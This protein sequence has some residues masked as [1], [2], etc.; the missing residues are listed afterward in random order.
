[1]GT[2]YGGLLHRN[3]KTNISQYYTPPENEYYKAESKNIYAITQNHGLLWMA[4]AAGLYSFDMRSK[5][6]VQHINAADEQTRQLCAL[7]KCKKQNKILCGGYKGELRFFNLQ[8]NSW[9]MPPDKN[10]FMKANTFRARYMEERDNGDVYISTEQRCLIKYNY[11]SGVFTVYPQFEKYSATSRYFC[12]DSSYLWIAT[13]DGLIQ[14]S[15]KQMQVIKVWT[16]VNGLLNDYVYGAVPYKPG[17]IW[18]S[19]NS[20]LSL[21]DYNKNNCINYT[22]NDGLQ[23]NEFNTASC[24]KDEPGRIWFGGI[25]GMNMIDTGGIATSS[26]IP[27]PLLT[28]IRVMN[29]PLSSDSAVSYLHNIHLSYKNNFL[30]FEF[31]C[32]DYV[33]SDNINYRYKMTGIDTGWINNESRNAVNF[34]QLKPG[35]YRFLVQ[36]FLGNNVW[37]NTSQPIEITI[38]TPWYNQWWFYVLCACTISFIT[39]SI[40]KYRIAQVRK[41]YQ[42]QQRISSD[43]HDDIGASLT[44]INIL[45]KLS[46]QKNIDEAARRNYLEKIDTQTAE[47]TDALRDIVWS[48]NPKNNALDNITGKMKRYA[49]EVLEAKNIDYDFISPAEDATINLD[50]KRRQNIYFIFKEAI[51]NIAKYSEAKHVIIKLSKEK[52]KLR[53]AISDDGKGFNPATVKQGNGLGNMQRRAAAINAAY[54]IMAAEGRGVKLLLELPL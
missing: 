17:K 45:S 48:I 44:S 9:E 5:I 19:T 11:L 21:I 40:F 39:Y 22:I 50:I 12:F 14:A 54:N 41:M 6:F 31:Q 2:L 42:L 25:N 29:N 43:L 52:S 27:V 46:N 47:V 3:L 16:T 4:T 33:H 24:L 10:N 32:P 8:T 26:I 28:S 35:R 37:S 36:A 15:A 49:A 38:D 34:T 53:L 51:N 20:G 1:M 7:I 30:S 18:I 13:D 23:D